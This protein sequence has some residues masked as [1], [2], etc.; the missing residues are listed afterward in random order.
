MTQDSI[1]LELKNLPSG[2]YT[3]CV[4]A[5]NAYGKTS[6]PLSAT[7]RVG[8]EN[9]WQLICER[10]LQWFADVKEYVVRWFR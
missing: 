3:I 4:T 7:V 10:I 5:E 9:A 1:E 8:D 2:K 6:Q